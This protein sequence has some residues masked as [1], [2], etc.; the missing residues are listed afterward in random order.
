MAKLDKSKYTKDEWRAI[1]EQ[2]RLEKMVSQER[3]I[4]EKSSDKLNIL[5]V[6]F[7]NK[8]GPHYVKIL[9]NMIQR[10]ISVPYEIVCLTDDPTPIEGVRLI[11]RKNQ[12]YAKGWWHKVH[13]FDPN[14]PLE[15]RILYMDLDVV[16]CNNIDK[17]AVYMPK[18][19]VGI[20][21]FNRKF[22]ADWKYLNSSVMAWHAGTQTHIWDQFN[23][24]R[25]VAMRMQGDQD[26]IWKTSKDKIKFFPETWIQSYKWEIRSRDDIRLIDG[27]R[28]FV[29]VNDEVKPHPECAIAVFHGEP[30]PSEVRDKFV[31]ENWK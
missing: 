10:H 20:R 24:E 2:R 7:G 17:I 3:Q 6:R 31:T 11:V 29:K 15:G 14:L 26:W 28:N 22:H 30:N 4:I 23:K 1:R 25:T 9:R 18:N 13:M 21:D 19:F 16:I 5:C 27:K 12:G 8:Y